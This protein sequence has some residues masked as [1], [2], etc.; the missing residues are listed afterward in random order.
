MLTVTRKRLQVPAFERTLYAKVARKIGLKILE[1]KLTPGAVLPNE[2]DFGMQ[3]GVSRTALREAVK[4]LAAKGFV[5][6]RR[7]TGTRVRPQHDWNLLDP[8]VLNWM[9]SGKRFAVYI[10]DLLELSHMIQPAG[11]KLAAERA[12]PENLAEIESALQAMETGEEDSASSLESAL[13]FHLAILKATHNTFMRPFG[14][15]IQEALRARFK[16]SDRDRMAFKKSLRRHRDVFEAICD[17]N[18]GAAEVAMQMVLNGGV[19]RNPRKY[20]GGKRAC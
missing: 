17:R 1:G 19:R 10:P 16:L 12:T 4:V 7:K 3:H 6:V 9:I 18:P 20:R 5:E 13:T 8:D 15:L 14:A 11:A 2:A